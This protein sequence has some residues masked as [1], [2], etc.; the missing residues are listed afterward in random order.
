MRERC[1]SV[2][3][4]TF[5]LFGGVVDLERENGQPVDDEAGGLGVERRVLV[6]FAGLLHQQG[7]DLLHVVIALLVVLVDVVLYLGDGRIRGLRVAS[8]I[9][10]MPQVEVSAMLEEHVDG[11]LIG[12]ALKG[13]V[14]VPGAVGA[15]VEC[16]DVVGVEHV[17]ER[18]GSVRLSNAA[19]RRGERGG[20]K[21][22]H[23]EPGYRTSQ[24]R[25]RQR[26]ARTSA[27]RIRDG[28]HDGCR[29]R[30]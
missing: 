23:A 18:Y 4:G 21:V 22:L 26:T 9:L 16:D 1:S 29:R 10:L 8:F 3:G 27:R 7:V 19:A 14:Q 24:G 15:V 6:L 2:A 13:L 25:T 17:R 28:C 12:L 11:E 5:G 20:F 30:P